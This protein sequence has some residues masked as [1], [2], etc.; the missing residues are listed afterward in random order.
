MSF[1]IDVTTNTGASG[2]ADSKICIFNFDVNNV[3]IHVF[4]NG[5]HGL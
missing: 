2:A 4:G 3:C 5:L 1:D